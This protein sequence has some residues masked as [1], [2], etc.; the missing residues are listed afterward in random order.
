MFAGGLVHVS[1]A[2]PTECESGEGRGSSVCG[3]TISPACQPVCAV[4]SGYE[5]QRYFL[6]NHILKSKEKSEN[7]KFTYRAPGWL[8]QLSLQLLILAQVMISELW[9]RALP[10]AL[11]S[12]WSLFISLSTLPPAHTV[13]LSLK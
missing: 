11:S 13:S 1:R 4:D 3:A 10:G 12:V 8:S 2:S 5:P 9:D 7:N 6:L